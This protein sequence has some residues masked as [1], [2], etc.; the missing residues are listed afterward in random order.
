M[1]HIQSNRSASGTAADEVKAAATTFHDFLGKGD[2]QD[3]SPAMSGRVVLSSEASPSASI[4]LGASSGGGRG[5]ISTTSDLGSGN[6]K[7]TLILTLLPVS[8]YVL[9]FLCNLRG[10]GSC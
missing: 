9:L 5:P 10:N 3:S 6:P 1:A 4:S 7:P 8:C 2:P